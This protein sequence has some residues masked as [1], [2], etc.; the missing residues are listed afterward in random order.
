MNAAQWILLLILGLLALSLICA[1]AASSLGGKDRDVEADGPKRVEDLMPLADIRGGWIFL[2]DGSYR[3][4][5]SWPGR[6][7]SLDTEAERYAK[8]LADARM[9]SAADTRM[10]ILKYPEVTSSSAQLDLV[11]AAIEREERALL[12]CPEGP[13]K[14]M[15]RRK[16][17]ILRDGMREDALIES[18]GSGRVSWPT[19]LIM[20][21]EAGHDVDH[22]KQSVDNFI[23][24]ANEYVENAPRWMTE[25]E[26]R[27]LLQLYFTP[28]TV[29][30]V[31]APRGSAVLP[32]YSGLFAD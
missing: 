7:Q 12:S 6:N 19:A 1:K 14:E 18:M 31:A 28:D 23:K 24:A 27:H 16:A 5:L 15:H 25:A 2:K 29:S 3:A 17:E 8:A 13:E 11:D 9:L 4:C 26:V 10:A 30:D 21:F 32:D 22:A 20:C